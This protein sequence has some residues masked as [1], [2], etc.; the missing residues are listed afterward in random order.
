MRVE[1]QNKGGCQ[2]LGGGCQGCLIGKVNSSLVVCESSL[3]NRISWRDNF[4]FQI[5][6]FKLGGSLRDRFL[7]FM[8][9]RRV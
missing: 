6:D 8:A 2:L 9:S 3:V 1:E 5:S 4:I 7:I